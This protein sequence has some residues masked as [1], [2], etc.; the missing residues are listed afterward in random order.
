MHHN[1]VI[2]LQC[3]SW[4]YATQP[5]SIQPFMFVFLVRKYRA[6]FSYLPHVWRTMNVQHTY[7]IRKYEREQNRE[8]HWAI[9]RWWYCLFAH[10]VG[11]KLWLKVSNKWNVKHCY[12]VKLYVYSELYT[13]CF[14]LFVLCIQ[15][16]I[17][18]FCKFLLKRIEFKV[19]E[20][21]VDCSSNDRIEHTF[22]RNKHINRFVHQSECQPE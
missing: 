16:F 5:N 3:E 7:N 22:T 6:T 20:K 15:I 19:V 11:C 21:P 18:L 9:M 14:Q 13:M 4:N 2:R 8:T 12:Q 10:V 17:L 1:G